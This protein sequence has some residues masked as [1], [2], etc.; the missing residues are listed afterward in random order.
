MNID[1]MF[2]PENTLLL[3][4]T[5]RSFAKLSVK[6][7]WQPIVDIVPDQYVLNKFLI[8][9]HENSLLMNWTMY[10]HFLNWLVLQDEYNAKIDDQFI[11][12]ILVASV[13]RWVTNGMDHVLAK[14]LLLTS[15]HLSEIIMGVYKSEEADRPGKIITL[16]QKISAPK[17]AYCLVYKNKGDAHYLWEDFPL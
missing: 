17:D 11:K 4:P 1:A 12:K 14:G 13:M 5:E 16:K 15:Q 9:A 10:L 3:S 8:W 6:N 2:L 7:I